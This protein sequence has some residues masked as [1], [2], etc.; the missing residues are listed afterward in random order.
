MQIEKKTIKGYWLDAHLVVSF[1]IGLHNDAV[2]KRKS[3][4]IIGSPEAH[5][6]DG[7]IAAIK[8]ILDYLYGKEEY[9]NLR[10]RIPHGK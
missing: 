9:G 2:D 7:M 8:G 10:V 3:I 5:K 4:K 6:V 1:L